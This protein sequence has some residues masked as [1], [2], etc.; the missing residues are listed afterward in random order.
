MS[1]GEEQGPG[2]TGT[3]DGS[4]AADGITIRP[5]VAAEEYLDCVRLQQEIW[6]DEFTEAV[7]TTIMRVVQRVGGVTAGAF[8]ETGE[9]LGFVFGMTGVLDGQLVHWSDILA[10]RPS[11]RNHG[12]GRRLKMYQRDAVR[13]LGVRTMY[14]TFDPLVAKNAYLNLVRLGARPTEYAVDYYG[15]DT[16]SPLHG[17]LGTDRFIVAWDLTAEPHAHAERD[18]ASTADPDVGP[19]IVNPV[20]DAGVPRLVSL[21]SDQMVRIEIP[22]DIYG[23]LEHAP[24]VAHA[25]RE[26]TRRAFTWYQSHGYR[27]TDFTAHATPRRSFYTLSAPNR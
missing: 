19:R 14:W 27:V 26:S 7:P 8:N 5:V 2:A 17:S 13:A 25:W 3:A 20:G 24:T 6:G 1:D 16:G 11:A 12:I 18:A 9:L 4:N 23:L 22:P 21:P 10:V 15:P